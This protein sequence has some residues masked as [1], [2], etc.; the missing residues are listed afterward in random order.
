[1]PLD[2]DDEKIKKGLR[3]LKYYGIV[4]EDL[5]LTRTGRAV[6]LKVKGRF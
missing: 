6:Y 3:E 4:N 5:K 2:C 1:M